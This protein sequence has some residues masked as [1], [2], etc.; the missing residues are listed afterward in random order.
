MLPVCEMGGKERPDTPEIKEL[1]SAKWTI[2]AD[3]ITIA[4]PKKANQ[5]A[6]LPTRP[7]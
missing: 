3:K 1:K 6:S 4:L 5:E 7:G 2:K